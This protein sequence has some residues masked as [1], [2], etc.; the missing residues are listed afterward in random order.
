MLGHKARISQFQ[1]IK[2]HI[3]YVLYNSK[4]KTDTTKKDND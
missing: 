1:K 3:E 2:N 4:I